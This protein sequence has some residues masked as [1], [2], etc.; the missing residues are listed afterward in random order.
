MRTVIGEILTQVGM[1]SDPQ[2]VLLSNCR[3]HVLFIGAQIYTKSNLEV[4]YCPD[5]NRRI[6]NSCMTKIA[7]MVTFNFTGILAEME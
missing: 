1:V 7:G 2:L 3:P 5:Y 6:T 4:Y